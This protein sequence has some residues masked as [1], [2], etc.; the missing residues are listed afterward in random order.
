M[1]VEDFFKAKNTYKKYFK[2]LISRIL[3]TTIIVLIILIICNLSTKF[4]SEVNK[5]VYETNYNF[6]KINS[7]YKKYLL[8]LKKE[9]EKV[10]NKVTELVSKSK[11]FD[12]SEKKPFKD[13]VLLTVGENYPV[14][15]MESGLIVY[16]GKKDDMD[17]IVME[18]SN[19]IDVV[20]GNVVTS[21]IKIY[22]FVEKG[23]IIGNT[24]NEELYLSFQKNKEVLNYEPYIEN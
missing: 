8:S 6:S 7:L 18:Q 2:S 3:L 11:T 13:G 10:N 14:K 12:Y 4:K 15:T 9:T 23:I 22:D 20:F 21:D 24:N 16:I 19:G 5:Y 1:R 17:T